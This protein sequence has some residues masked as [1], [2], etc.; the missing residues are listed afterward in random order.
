MQTKIALAG[1]TILLGCLMASS[2]V[3][4]SDKQFL[5][6]AIKDDNSEIMLG[7][8]AAQ[9][10]ASND[11]RSFGQ[12]LVDDHRKAKEEAATLAADLEVKITNGIAEGAQQELDKLQ[13]LTGP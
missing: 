6:D 13:R 1:A 3:A 8:L 12:A 11:V 9:K 5:S 4:K 7:Q 2:A 10:G